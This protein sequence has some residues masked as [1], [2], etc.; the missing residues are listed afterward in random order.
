MLTPSQLAR[1]AAWCKISHQ[2][3]RAAFKSEVG[4]YPHNEACFRALIW[5]FIGPDPTDPGADPREVDRVWLAPVIWRMLETE[6][7][8]TVGLVKGQLM[9]MLTIAGSNPICSDTAPSATLAL[10]HA[11]RAAGVPEVVEC[12]GDNSNG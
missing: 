1:L 2:T 6:D 10:L 5:T 3:H 11:A 7:A 8:I 12:M 4:G 9:A